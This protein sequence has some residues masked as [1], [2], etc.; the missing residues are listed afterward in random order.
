MIYNNNIINNITIIITECHTHTSKK[1][2]LQKVSTYV[3]K[4]QQQKERKKNKI[5]QYS[6]EGA[7]MFIRELHPETRVQVG[8]PYQGGSVEDQTEETAKH[9]AT[10]HRQADT[11]QLQVCIKRVFFLLKTFQLFTSM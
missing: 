7:G 2:L 8:R 10:T 5:S 6:W 11:K 9:H 1:T 3:I 4:Q